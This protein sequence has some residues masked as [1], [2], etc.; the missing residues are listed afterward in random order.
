MSSIRVTVTTEDTKVSINNLFFFL[1]ARLDLSCIEDLLKLL[2]NR[3]CVNKLDL[4][5]HIKIV[6]IYF[7]NVNQIYN[8]IV[9][10]SIDVFTTLNSKSV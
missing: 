7:L 4:T 3:L 8:R 9:F 10:N 2:N 5:L 6:F 1:S